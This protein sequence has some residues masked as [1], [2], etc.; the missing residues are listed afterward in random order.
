M[1]YG[2]I[3]M[4]AMIANSLGLNLNGGWLNEAHVLF[5][6]CVLCEMQEGI[7]RILF[8]GEAYI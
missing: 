4:T 8:L 7:Y 6:W 3:N 1:I 5:K 2:G